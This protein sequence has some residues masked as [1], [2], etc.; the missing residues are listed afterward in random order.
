MTD[1]REIAELL[2]MEGFNPIPLNNDKTPATHLA[3]T[4]YLYEPQQVNDSYICDRIGVTCGIAS[5]GLEVIDF[6]CHQ[7]QDIETIFN[8]YVTDQ[9]V[10]DIITNG[11]AAIYCTPSGGYH[12]MIRSGRNFGGSAVF[13]RYA[14]NKVMIEVRGGGA[15][16][17]CAP[18]EGYTFL[19]GAEML[20][21]QEIDKDDRAYLFNLAKTYNIGEVAKHKAGN[22]AKWGEWDKSK[23]WGKYNDEQANEAKQLL[24]DNGWTLINN[25]KND[26]VELWRRP[27]KHKGIS[28]TFGQYHNMFYCFTSSALP[29]DVNKAYSP[30]DILMLLK[31]KGDWQ[32]TKAHLLERY[33]VEEPQVKIQDVDKFPIDVFPN[34]IAEYIH[35][36]NSALNYKQDFIAVSFMFAVATL[37]GNKFKLRVKNGWTSATTF[38]FAVVG[39]SGVMKTH[40]VNQ[41]VAPLKQLDRLSKQHYD[42]ELKDYNKLDDKEKKNAD[43]PGFRQIMI[44]DITLEEVHNVH[45]FNA[46]GLGYH[47]DELV[48]FINDMNK[49]RKGSDEQ[50]WLESFNNSSYVVN[51]VTKEPMMIDNIMINIIG[52]IQ[53]GVLHNAIGAANGNG[54]IERFLYT[55][56]ESNVYPLSNL[57]INIDWINWYNSE[58]HKADTRL[59][60]SETELLE[61]TPE[62]FGLLIKMDARLCALQQSDDET[63]GMKNYIN[64]IKTY[65]PRFALLMC[66]IDYCFDGGQ[67]VVNTN[68]M[69]RATK[70]ADYFIRSARHIFAEG[71]RTSEIK[72]VGRTLVQKGMSKT[73]QIM[74][75]SKKGF[76]QVEIA[77]M[78]NTP[79]SYVSKVIKTYTKSI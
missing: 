32:A 58:M 19:A 26:G 2:T 56:S 5:G 77:K 55:T 71:E 68:H 14:D 10:I 6:D 76:K 9:N 57:D 8:D 15:Y 42:R 43:K 31:F 17:V 35:D 22:G 24:K 3:G 62:A 53:P 30:T 54:L 37:N 74:E 60:F 65:M 61:M 66:V 73:E 1:Y 12:L 75:L 51:R 45:K 29:F 23:A 49:Y 52:G 79:Y 72:T 39:E 78:L 20:K 41:M 33:K 70:L 21:L 67:K 48:G 50:F 27:D 47:K 4:N 46:R 16:V 34:D 63:N 13:A 18:S 28:A 11:Q 44:S 59:S 36:L 7:G 64:K 25:R 38:W 69:E 40:P